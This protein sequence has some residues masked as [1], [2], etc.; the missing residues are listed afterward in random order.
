MTPQGM[1]VVDALE[2]IARERKT[3]PAAVALAWLLARPNV[4]APII[5]ANTPAQLADLLPASGLKLSPTDIATLD[6]ASEGM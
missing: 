5:G 2:E 4:T 1:N 3:T 6:S